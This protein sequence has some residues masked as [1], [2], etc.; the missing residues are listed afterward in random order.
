MGRA[1]FALLIESVTDNRN[2]TVAEI[3]HI[4]SKNGWQPRGGWCGRLDF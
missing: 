2:R 1:A 3:R 4:F